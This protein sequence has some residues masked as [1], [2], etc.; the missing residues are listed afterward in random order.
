MDPDGDLKAAIAG[1]F[2]ASPKMGIE[3]TLS[4]H[5]LAG[6]GGAV[7]NTKSISLKKVWRVQASLSDLRLNRD[8]ILLLR[9]R[10]VGKNRMRH[11]HTI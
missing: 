7:V 2:F 3:S 4:W 10:E 8:G 1:N 11:V 6:P 5:E 9:L